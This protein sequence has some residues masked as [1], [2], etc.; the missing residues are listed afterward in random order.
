LEVAAD[1]AH[2][3]EVRASQPQDSSSRLAGYGLRLFWARL[4]QAVLQLL[5]LLQQ[6]AVQAALS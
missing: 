4:A 2:C 1:A 3:Y 5:Q 6:A